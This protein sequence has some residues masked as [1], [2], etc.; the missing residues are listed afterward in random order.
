LPTII[1]LWVSIALSGMFLGLFWLLLSAAVVL[2]GVDIVDTEIAFD[3]QTL[4]LRGLE[5][6]EQLA[7]FQQTQINFSRDVI[8]S[9]FQSVIPV[10]FWFLIFGPAGGLF[11][12][13]CQHYQDNLD[14]NS[15]EPDF[16]DLLL[17]WLEWIPSRLTILLFALLGDFGRTYQVFAESVVDTES[18]I[19][20]T[21][22]ESAMS[23]VVGD[24][25]SGSKKVVHKFVSL[26]ES[27]LTA[28]KLLLER[29][30]WGWVGIAA[31]LTI[32]GL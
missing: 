32:L 17:Y 29:S 31:L 11:L 12:V 2:Y 27:E 10:L 28:L 7:R 14:D 4:W 13:L 26:A 21:L 6:T 16:L 15:E 18:A 3:D 5:E 23:A 20:A 19:S 22:Y 30:L 25:S 9:V 1:V 8:Y 24:N